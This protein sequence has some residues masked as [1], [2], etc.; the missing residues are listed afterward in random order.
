MF[1]SG[2]VP[3]VPSCFKNCPELPLGRAKK[4]ELLFKSLV[5]A[6]IVGFP[7]KLLK[8]PSKESV[9]PYPANVVGLL[10]KLAKENVV[11]PASAVVAEVP[12]AKESVI[13]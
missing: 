8:A 13:P 1:V 12:K 6:G 2:G 4:L 11:F 3:K 9:I 10:V 5:L 7:L